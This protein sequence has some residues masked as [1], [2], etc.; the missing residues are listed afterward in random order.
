[1]TPPTTPTTTARRLAMA[2]AGAVALWA[3]G[4]GRGPALSA[5]ELRDDYARQLVKGVSGGFTVIKAA[6]YDAATGML[7]DVRIDDGERMIHAQRAEILV[8]TEKQTVSLRLHDVVGADETTGAW[9]DLEGLT[10]EPVRVRVGR[11]DE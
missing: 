3:A 10:T 1:M 5:D 11:A 2:L 6:R 4:C 8:S 7:H 9:I